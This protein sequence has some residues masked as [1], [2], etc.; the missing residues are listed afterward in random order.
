[1]SPGLI[2]ASIMPTPQPVPPIA[3]KCLSAEDAL[4]PH[5]QQNSYLHT[6]QVIWLQP[7]FFSILVRHIGQKEMLSLINWLS[8]P[9]PSSYC[10][11][12][13]SQVSLPCQSLRHLKQISVAH[14][15]QLNFVASKLSA[16]MNC[17]QPTLGHHLTSGSLS[18]LFWLLKRLYFSN[19]SERSRGFKILPILSS[20]I[21]YPHSPWGHYNLVISAFSMLIFIC[22]IAQSLQKRCLHSNSTVPMSDSVMGF[23]SGTTSFV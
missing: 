9:Q 20:E 8:L 15:G 10:F 4:L 12:A 3:S 22:S 19:K 17:S 23:A 21:S 11:M 13:S 5:A 16:F 7:S 18:K 1:M 2:P 6:V 14:F